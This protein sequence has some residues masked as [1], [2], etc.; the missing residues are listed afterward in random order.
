[1]RVRFYLFAAIV[2][3]ALAAHLLLLTGRVS[4][5]SEDAMRSRLATASAAVSMQIALIDA[6]LSARG[7]A[8]SPSLA[9]AT[10]PGPDGKPVKPDE[11]AL[12]AAASRLRNADRSPARR[13][14]QPFG[15]APALD[16]APRGAGGAGQFPRYHRAGGG[17]RLRGAVPVVARPLPGLLSLRS[18]ALPHRRHRL[19]LAPRAKGSR[20]PSGAR[21]PAASVAAGGRRFAFR[22]VGPVASIARGGR[23]GA[24]RDREARSTSHRGALERRRRGRRRRERTDGAEARHAVVRSLPRAQRSGRRDRWADGRRRAGR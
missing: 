11:R 16:V 14:H 4:Q 8:Q 1:M 6:T 9:D 3:I 13:R 12:R 24:E 21:P 23:L 20:D 15:K 2:L 22:C 18:R 10:R 17:E 5:G 19:G 7:A